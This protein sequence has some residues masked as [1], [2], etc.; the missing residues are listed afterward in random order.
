MCGCVCQCAGSLPDSHEICLVQVINADMFIT[1][2]ASV[3]SCG[4]QR[5]TRRHLIPSRTRDV[6]VTGVAD[7]VGL[8]GCQLFIFP[9]YRVCVFEWT[10]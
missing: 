2:P 7:R 6:T 4:G 5:I 1:F 9:P 10:Q 3:L 8:S